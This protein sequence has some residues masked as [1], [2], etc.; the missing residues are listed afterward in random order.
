MHHSSVSW[1]ITLLYFFSW[2]CT[3]FGQK[4]PIK[5]QISDFQL[6]KY[7]YFDRLLLLKVYKILSKKVQR[8][9]V[10]R[11]WRLMPNLKE[12]WSVVSK[13]TRIW[14]NLTQLLESLKICA[15][16]C[17]FCGKYVMF[18]LKKCR[19]VIFYDTEKW[20]KIWRKTHLWFE[21]W[22]EKFGNFSPK[23]LKVS[24]L[25]LWWDP[26]VQSRKCMS[27]K[28]TEELFARTIIQNPRGID[29]PF[30]NW[31]EEF[32]EFCFEHSKL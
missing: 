12:N 30:Q 10:S 19:G 7:L 15:F 22:H 16:I 26:F 24:K 11:P 20:W 25:G 6:L 5:V 21:K 3:W 9:Y 2:N 27:L 31:Y 28:L 29:L 8:N 18:D 23:H 32:D 13:M 1:E 4:E 17:S 14:W